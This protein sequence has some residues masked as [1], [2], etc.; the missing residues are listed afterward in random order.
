MQR[1]GFTTSLN[2]LKISKSCT[3]VSTFKALG[4]ECSRHPCGHIS[5]TFSGRRGRENSFI[6][7]RERARIVPRERARLAVNWNHSFAV[8]YLRCL[9][10]SPLHCC[11][12][13]PPL[14]LH[15]LLSP[16]WDD[17]DIALQ[18]VGG[19]ILAHKSTMCR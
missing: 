15:P 13:P 12:R 4:P 19:N 7:L 2:Q 11:C 18:V 1:Q 10:H 14:L 17:S 5:A 6:F 8:L 3:P 9:R 16:L